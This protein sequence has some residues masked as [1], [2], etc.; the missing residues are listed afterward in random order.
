MCFNE[1]LSVFMVKFQ[2]EKQILEIFAIRIL[3][4]INLDIEVNIGHV[5]TIHT[6]VNPDALNTTEK[7]L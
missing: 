7:L 3:F 2:D 1:V 6:L 5:I 4:I